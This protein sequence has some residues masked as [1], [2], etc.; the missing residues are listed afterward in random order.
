MTHLQKFEKEFEEKFE[1]GSSEFSPED[2][3]GIWQMVYWAY[4]KGRQTRERECAEL[5]SKLEKSGYDH[6][7]EEKRKEEV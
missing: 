7:V 6:S 2:W 5:K 1:A 3:V 4:H